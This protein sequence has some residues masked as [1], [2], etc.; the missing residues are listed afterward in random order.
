MVGSHNTGRSRQVEVNYYIETDSA[1]FSPLV[2]DL[3]A[4]QK[5]REETVEY[6]RKCLYNSEVA[7]DADRPSSKIIEFL[8]VSGPAVAKSSTIGEY[9]MGQYGK[10]CP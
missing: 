7:P 2:S 10:G 6:I 5:F 1:E 9:P 4:A 3:Q 8:R